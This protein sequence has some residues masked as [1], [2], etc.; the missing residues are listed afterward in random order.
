MSLSKNEWRNLKKKQKKKK[1]KKK[2]KKF[3]HGGHTNK[4]SD[5]S[6]NQNEPMVLCSV[7]EDNIMQ[8]WQMAMNIYAE[9]ETEVVPS[10]LES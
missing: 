4:V 8:I 1:K 10:E 2:K 3:I 9:E 5:F 6:W 7:A